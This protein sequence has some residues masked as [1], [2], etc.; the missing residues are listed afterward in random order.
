MG[1]RFAAG[2]IFL[3]FFS[4]LSFIFLFFYIYFVRGSRFVE[5]KCNIE[6]KSLNIELH[7][8]LNLTGSWKF[9]ENPFLFCFDCSFSEFS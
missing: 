3:F 4:F 9:S 8:C 1:K 2:E 5:L 7:L 6:L